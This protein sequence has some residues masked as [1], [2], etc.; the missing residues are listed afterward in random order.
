MAI[1]KPRGKNGAIPLYVYDPLL[2]RK[3]YK[4]SYATPEEARDAQAEFQKALR[5]DESTVRRCPGCRKMFR[6][7]DE[8]QK[9]C[10]ERCEANVKQRTR[11]KAQ[12]REDD[13]WVYTCL[14]ADMEVIYVGV[15]STG[16]RRHREHGRDSAWWPDVAFIRV[17]H[18]ATREDALKAELEGIQRHRPVH[19]TL[20]VV[21]AKASLMGSCATQGSAER[22]SRVPVC[23]NRGRSSYGASTTL[24]GSSCAATGHVGMRARRVSRLVLGSQR[25]ASHAGLGCLGSKREGG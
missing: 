15:T 11:R 21:E 19:N 6:P 2:K 3:V 14:N 12:R 8:W 16:L 24:Q 7:F 20:H 17:Q 5:G 25:D 1:G 23:T 4:G 9:R 22:G 13:H 10:S 18:F